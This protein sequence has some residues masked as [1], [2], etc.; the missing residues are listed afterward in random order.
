MAA[1]QPTNQN[2]KNQNQNKQ[3]E[4][5]AED[6]ALARQY[7]NMTEISNRMG[8]AV[9]TIIRWKQQLNFPCFLM[10]GCWHAYEKDIRAWEE[11]RKSGKEESFKFDDAE[12]IKEAKK[13]K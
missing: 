3:Q 5:T 1:G 9:N 2:N 13:K 10:G 8:R 6:H 12:K 7:R 11:H 4:K